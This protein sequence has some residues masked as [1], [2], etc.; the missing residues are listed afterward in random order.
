MRL[1]KNLSARKLLYK[2]KIDLW[3]TFIMKKKLSSRITKRI[4]M[5]FETLTRI[6]FFKQLRRRKI[7]ITKSWNK[8]AK[9]DSPFSF[10]SGPV[11]K[12]F[13]Y[14]RLKKFYYKKRFKK[15][16]FSKNFRFRY[17]QKYLIYKRIFPSHPDYRYTKYF[18]K[19]RRERFLR[20]RF[21]YFNIR[22]WRRIKVNFKYY[23]SLYK[24]SYFRVPIFK[25]FYLIQQQRFFKNFFLTWKYSYYLQKLNKLTFSKNNIIKKS[26]FLNLFNYSSYYKNKLHFTPKLESVWLKSHLARLKFKLPRSLGKLYNKYSLKWVFRRPYKRL[27]SL[28][29]FN[30]I[31][32][33]KH[34]NFFCF[35]TLSQTRKFL[36]KVE[37]KRRPDP[38][39]LG[40]EGCFLNL[41]FRTNLFLNT[42]QIYNFIKIGA[43]QINDKI[44]FNPY[45]I[46]SIFDT[47]SINKK[48]IKIIW[49]IFF[50]KIKRRLILVNIPNYMDYDY[51]LLKFFIW[52]L[53]TEKER[54]FSYSYPF[55]RPFV[56]FTKIYP[57]KFKDI[58]SLEYA[59]PRNYKF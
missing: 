31:E 14:K 18:W 37:F 19:D 48:F 45:K 1:E 10:V 24:F 41:L 57:S 49:R 21:Y 3:G 23:N 59:P 47:F 20:R 11:Q 55:F 34:L 51:Q 58:S 28:N 38:I 35:S 13:Q 43:I 52:R 6:H 30:K 53:P 2:F 42:K 4:L 56:N 16:K 9:K 22:R 36:K 7:K 12:K 33:L 5:E 29:Y 8:K 15:K 50:K 27:P 39:F 32:L 26:F 54:R 44:N 25:K 17:G 46:L 40:L